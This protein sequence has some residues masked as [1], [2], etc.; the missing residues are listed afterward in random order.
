MEWEN[1]DERVWDPL[2]DYLSWS[3]DRPVIRRVYPGTQA[4]EKVIRLRYAGLT[5]SGFVDVET[6]E[7]SCMRLE[8]DCESIILG[9]FD[10]GWCYATVTL[11]TITNAYPGLA[12]E[13]EK[14]ADLD[15]PF[16]RHP[17]TIEITKLVIAPERRNSRVGLR[18]YE[19]TAIIGRLL[20]KHH[21]WQVGRDIERDVYARSRVGFDYSNGYR[22]N[23]ASLND[24]PSRIGYMNLL[25]VLD[26][27]NVSKAFLPAYRR[28]LSIPEHEFLSLHTA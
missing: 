2:L 8:R 9:A 4:Y 21:F 13:L 23:D 27:P 10:G 11:N 22:F 18:L 17:G 1:I 12:M 24:T 7:I 19:I 15:H 6:M 26:N 3:D 28:V 5:E 14:G 25:T 16:F 20:G